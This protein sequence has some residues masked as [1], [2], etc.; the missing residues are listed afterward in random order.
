MDEDVKSELI[1]S[2]FKNIDVLSEKFGNLLSK[3]SRDGTK[4][5]SEPAA[6]EDYSSANLPPFLK[7]VLINIVKNVLSKEKTE[8]LK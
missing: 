2:E 1:P 4:T 8:N 3:Q 7:Q 5:P 6:K